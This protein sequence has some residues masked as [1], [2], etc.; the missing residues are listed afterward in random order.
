MKLF[1]KKEDNAESAAELAPAVE[2]DAAEQRPLHYYR[3]ADALK[4]WLMPFV[5][6]LCFGFPT[7]YGGIVSVLSGFAPLCFFL[8]SG[9]FGLIDGP[10][11]L[12]RLGRRIKRTG[13]MFAVMFVLCF[14]TN[15]LFYQITGADVRIVFTTLLQKRVLFNFFVLCVWPFSMGES[16]WFI[17][18]LFYAYIVLYVLYRLHLERLRGLLLVL[19]AALM[20]VS[21]E[22]AG[23]VG[24]QFLGAPYLPPNV[25]TR[26]LP[27]VLLGG[28]IRKK[29]DTWSMR[30][31]W[32]YLL[33]IP[34]GLA[35]A[36]GEFELLASRGLLVTTS[37]AVGLG[38]TA[39]GLCMWTLFYL[40]I[41]P[42]F[43][44]VMGRPVARRLY[45]VSQLV[46]FLLIV[47]V[48]MFSQTYGELVRFLGGLIVYPVCLAPVL[49]IS[50][51]AP[52][53]WNLF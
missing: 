6:I 36:Y 49:I 42:N 16:I 11:E 1:R 44:C 2:T 25:F 29:M 31:A 53:E 32:L 47:P 40:H 17:Q 51:T 14:I 50:M 13:A 18:S 52:D 28:V 24:F 10:G 7:R 46:A 41:R 37:H 34:L 21:G 43:F 8:L 19:C 35:L 15:I 26:A 38:I 48:S 20:L 39:F 12:E 5:C 23:V 45:L 4:F 27:Y 3:T 33:M 22:L 30:G 9:F